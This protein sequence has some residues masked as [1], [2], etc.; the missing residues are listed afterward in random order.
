[1]NKPIVFWLM[2]ALLPALL[3]A[4][5]DVPRFSKYPV[6]GSGCF[7][8]MPAD[9]G[10]FTASDSEDGSKVYVGEAVQGD[11]FFAAIV[12]Q[13][14]A[15]LDAEDPV[16]GW[17]FDVHYDLMESY[18]NFLQA[19][20]GVTASAGYGRGHKMESNS[21]AVGVIDYWQDGEG[22][23]YAVKSWCDPHFLAVLMVY[24]PGEYPHFNAQEMYLNGFRFPEQ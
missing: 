14:S 20:L 15:P 3:S 21:M 1:M 12:V 22:Q 10:E 9:P 4:Q 16:T 7:V 18:L 5:T 13:L 6:A 2:L 24:G 8:Y 11:F 17:D 19:Q 23:Q